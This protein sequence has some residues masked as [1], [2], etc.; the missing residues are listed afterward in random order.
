MMGVVFGALLLMFRLMHTVPGNPWSNYV[1]TQR[2]RSGLTV[3]EATRAALARHFDLDLPLGRQFTRDIIGAVDAVGH[4]RGGG[5]MRAVWALHPSAWA[6]CAGGVVRAAR[7]V[8]NHIPAIILFEAA[9]GY[10][11]VGVTAA[12]D[13]D[14]FTVVGWGGLFYA[15]RSA[16]SHT[17]MM[18]L[19]PAL[20]LL[21]L[22]MG[23]IF[24]G[25]LLNNL[26]R[27]API[28]AE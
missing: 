16:L 27:R 19:T 4:W 11:G 28:S 14:E 25:N 8:F 7:R 2:A 9:L 15:G 5:G 23:F 10:I 18:L 21:M 3:D 6:H 24:L 26:A 20:G 1:A 17:P 13:G 12:V 22:S